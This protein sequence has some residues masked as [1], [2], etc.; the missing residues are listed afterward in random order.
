MG[1]LNS[2]QASPHP[3]N[4]SENKKMGHSRRDSFCTTITLPQLWH[5]CPELLSLE[6]V[7]VLCYYTQVTSGQAWIPS[8]VIKLPSPQSLGIESSLDSK[9]IKLVSPKGNQLWIFTGQTEVEA[10]AITLG[11]LV[12]DSCLI[13]KDPYAGKIEGRRRIGWQTMRWF[14]GITNSNKDLY[15]LPWWL[16]W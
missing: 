15:G 5:H 2:W 4:P 6:D 16:C 12:V 7:R 13:E 9:E 8:R 3:K 14:D 1:E 11:P 10:E